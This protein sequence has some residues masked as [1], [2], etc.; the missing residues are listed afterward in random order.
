MP[1]A[2]ARFLVG[3]LLGFALTWVSPWSVLALP[4]W[5]AYGILLALQVPPEEPPTLLGRT[6][7]YSG[8]SSA[9]RLEDPYVLG[10]VPL[11]LGLWFASTRHSW[12]DRWKR[13]VASLLAL[14]L[15]AGAVI[16][17]VVIC[18]QRGYMTTVSREPIEWVAL[19][20]IAA[21]RMLPV[22]LWLVLDPAQPF[23]NQRPGGIQRGEP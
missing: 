10:G 11:S 20:S 2:L 18:I 1:R 22:A 9:L 15:F 8:T 4:G 23:R 7:S 19:C 14:E 3:S 12:R 17:L 21:V 13:A 5:S 6:I 16:A